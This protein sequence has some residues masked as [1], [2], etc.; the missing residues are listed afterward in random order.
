ME[1][2]LHL[3][4]I[5][6][7]FMKVKNMYQLANTVLAITVRVRKGDGSQGGR[8]NGRV[9]G[10]AERVRRGKGCVQAD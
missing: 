8:Q 10:R 1:Q 9:G 3:E 6:K 5:R 4:K 2:L 7:F